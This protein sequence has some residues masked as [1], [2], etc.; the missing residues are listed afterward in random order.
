[1]KYLEKYFEEVHNF[2]SQGRKSKAVL[3]MNS[4]TVT[5]FSMICVKGSLGYFSRKLF[6]RQSNM[7]CFCL[8]T[9]V[10]YIT[11]SLQIMI[12]FSYFITFYHFNIFGHMC[13]AAHFINS[14]EV[15]LTDRR[16]KGRRLKM[17]WCRMHCHWEVSLIICSVTNY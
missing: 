9:A 2:L 11:S 15:A 12:I 6:C 13:C 16:I 7:W 17:V 5:C 8:Y 4:I 3:T 14:G 10:K 1:M